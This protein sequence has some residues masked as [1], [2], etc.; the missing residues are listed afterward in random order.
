MQRRRLALARRSALVVASA[1]VA[2]AVMP[3][4]SQAE[5]PVS[6]AQVEARLEALQEE[7][8][9]A[10]ELWLGVRA[11]AEGAQRRL[12]K[13]NAKALRSEAALAEMERAVGAFAAAAYRAG[14]LDQ[15]FSLLLADDPSEFL[16]QVSSLD[17]IARRQSD[18]L[19]RSAV[20]RQAF[21]NDTRI[22]QQELAA[23]EA[24]K[25]DLAAKKRLLDDK[26][27]AAEG[28]LASLKADQRRALEARQDA[29][30]A[31][32]IKEAERAAEAGRATR[33]GDRPAASTSSGSSGSGSQGASSSRAA[34]AVRYAL[35]QVGKRYVYAAAGPNAF[36]CSGLTMMAYRSVGVSLPH[37]SGMQYA[38]TRK[39]AASDLRP[40]DLVYYYS[41]ISH[42]AIYIGGGRIVD[43]AN[44]SAGV[45]IA[46]LYSMPFVGASRP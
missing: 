10:T 21:E 20:A 14:G 2:L 9:Q 38:S 32:A 25:A 19:H 31:A 26:V 44:P 45:R 3:A 1:V 13:A 17:G 11:E 42:V 41:P 43:A 30:R 28:M 4:V 46:P 35:A 23:L 40:G 34:G 8:E 18:A 33:G 27:S 36:D 16:A 22:A 29:A 37:Q 12:D 15:S 39:I 7:A 5:P 6:I 24:L